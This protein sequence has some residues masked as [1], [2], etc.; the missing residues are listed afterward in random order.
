MPGAVRL[1]LVTNIDPWRLIFGQEPPPT[2]LGFRVA[3][4][5][6]WLDVVGT[7]YAA[8]QVVSERFLD[9]LRR[10]PFT[11]W[12]SLPIKILEPSS[13]VEPYS[14]LL[15]TG[16]APA[17][18][19][20]FSPIEWRKPVGKGPGRYQVRVGMRFPLAGWDGSDV[21]RL[22]GTAHVVV[23][24]PVR[25]ELERAALTNVAL[26]DLEEVEQIVV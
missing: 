10:R 23:T 18:D 17:P 19:P 24:E 16:F 12:K 6:R 5:R 22:E 25:K 4:G 2:E 3:E 8:F 13:S 1:D 15:A 26:K 21:F 7:T 14:L 20:S 11:G 9:V